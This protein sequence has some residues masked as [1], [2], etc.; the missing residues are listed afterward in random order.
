MSQGVAQRPELPRTTGVSR[1]LGSADEAR[2]DWDGE[3]RG[4]NGKTASKVFLRDLSYENDLS[5]KLELSYFS[6]G[7]RHEMNDQS[8][9][10]CPRSTQGRFKKVLS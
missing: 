10:S 6:K 2:L 7:S 4:R 5:E 3:S 9:V 1:G 8:C